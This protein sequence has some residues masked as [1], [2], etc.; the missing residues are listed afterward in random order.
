MNKLIE[1]GLLFAA[2]SITG[3]AFAGNDSG[4]YV[5]GSVG[6]T[7]FDYSSNA[8]SFDDDDTAYKVFGGYNFG[9][10]PFLDVAAEISYIDFGSASVRSGEYSTDLDAATAAAIAGFNLGPVGLFGKAGIADWNSDLRI[11]EIKDS[12]SGTDAFYG[13]GAKVQFG[14]IAVR[15]EYERFDLDDYNLNLYTVGASYTF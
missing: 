6:N 1:T 5:G 2:C 15:A 13:L 12:D 14:S 10:V 3:A 9:L 4:F 7:D 11:A 8:V